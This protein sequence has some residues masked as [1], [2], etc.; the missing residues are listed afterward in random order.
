[1]LEVFK[2]SQSFATGIE[3]VD[4]QHQGLVEIINEAGAALSQGNAD[5][6]AMQAILARL[7]DYA[8]EHFRIEEGLMRGH[9]LDPR[10]TQQHV[11][12]HQ[13]FISQLRLIKDVLDDGANPIAWAMTLGFLVYWLSFHNLDL[14]QRMAVQMRL[15]AHGTRPSLA[16]DQSLSVR[17]S[18]ASREAMVSALTD[19]YRL[20][21]GAL[22]PPLKG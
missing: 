2:W 3:V 16:Y 8:G 5:P 20:S 13:H 12:D 10:H 1:M 17:A 7:F 14:D 22:L 15:I 19:I 11:A 9:G 6:E 18:D 4:L 21:A